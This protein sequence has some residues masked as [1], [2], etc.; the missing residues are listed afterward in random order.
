[1]IKFRDQIRSNDAD[2]AKTL[3]KK[4]ELA[5]RTWEYMQGYA[6]AKGE[7][8]RET[9]RLL[10]GQCRDLDSGPDFSIAIDVYRT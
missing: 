7:A 3:L 4:R 8:I 5:A 10:R 2:R 1:M 9:S 6:D